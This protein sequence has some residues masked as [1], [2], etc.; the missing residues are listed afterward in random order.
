MCP[1]PVRVATALAVVLAVGA[2]A[3]PAFALFGKAKPKAEA[4][5]KAASADPG[6]KAQPTPAAAKATTEQR[7]AAERMDPLARAAFWA[8]ELQADPGDAHASVGLSRA[9]RAL[10]RNDEAVQAAG[11]AVVMAPNDLE[12]L[13]EDAR[14]KIGAGQAF[15]A[16][17]GLRRAHTLAPADWRP[18]SLLGV[19]LEQSERPDEAREAYDQALALS[20]DNPAVLSNLGLFR[21]ARGETAQAETLLRRA[22][23]RPGATSQQRLNLALVLGLQ[24]KM[25][26]AERLIRQELPPPIA[27][28]NLAYL[29]ASL[30]GPTAAAAS[31]NWS[32]LEGTQGAT[33][34]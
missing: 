18:V 4:P 20:P 29:R 24:G 32:A 1:K 19:A 30:A 7:A 28:A 12:V 3:S 26:E 2:G 10:G 11:V 31:R 15:Y 23:T 17:E 6:D 14:A 8:R 5:A 34:R 25:A 22:A 33:P 9:L 27:N 21:A 13:L 16:I